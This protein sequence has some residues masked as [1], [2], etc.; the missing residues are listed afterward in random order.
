MH[1]E[2]AILCRL[3]LTNPTAT[4]REL[5]RVR[6]RNVACLGLSRPCIARAIHLTVQDHCIDAAGLGLGGSIFQH[7][8]ALESPS[9]HTTMRVR[10]VCTARRWVAV[11]RLA[12]V[13]RTRARNTKTRCQEASGNHRNNCVRSA[14]TVQLPQNRSVKLILSSFAFA[15]VLSCIFDS[16]LDKHAPTRRGAR[17]Q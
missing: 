1:A 3:G 16:H 12:Y 5:E 10:A 8:G 15:H 13:A 4:R 9:A 11:V 7:D 2:G 6:A 14:V 17:G